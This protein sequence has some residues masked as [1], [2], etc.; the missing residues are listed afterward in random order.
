MTHYSKQE[1]ESLIER[2]E[3]RILPKAEWTHEAHL[4]VA[5]WY[6]SKYSFNEALNLVR[7]ILP[8]TMNQ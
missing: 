8:A 1:I 3:K 7:E 6:V 5:I 2:F 4:A